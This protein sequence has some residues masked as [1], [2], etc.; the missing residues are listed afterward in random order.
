MSLLL[1]FALGAA[2]AA[3]AD[4]ADNALAISPRQIHALVAEY[5]DCIVKNERRAAEDAILKDVSDREFHDDYPQLVQELCIPNARSQDVQIDFTPSEMREAIAEALVRR[6]FASV[7]PP[8]LDDVPALS[9]RS[10]AEV[11]PAA[12]APASEI[13]ASERARADAYIDHFG[14]CVVRVDP[15][16]SKRLILTDAFTDA[17]AAAFNGMRTAL[18]TCLAEGKSLNFGKAALRGSIAINY[19]RLAVAARN[20]APGA[21]Q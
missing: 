10:V 12:S 8:V 21:A 1:S 6:E 18:G 17:E 4:P 7:P 11:Q 20:M 9:H 3:G 19:Y 14:E 15:A 2:A 13:A 16:G 5:A